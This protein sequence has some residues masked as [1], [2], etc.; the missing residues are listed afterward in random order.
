[1]LRI[2][3]AIIYKVSEVSKKC[4]WK[5]S[6]NLRKENTSDTE[7]E[8]FCMSNCFAVFDQPSCIIFLTW[9]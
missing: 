9:Y 7:K 5:K 1:M 8:I 6:K 4:I 3:P 2:S